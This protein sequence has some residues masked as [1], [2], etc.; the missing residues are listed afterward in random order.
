MSIIG[1]RKDLSTQ[2]EQLSLSILDL[3]AKG[4]LADLRIL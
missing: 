1:G 2:I 4:A 3:G